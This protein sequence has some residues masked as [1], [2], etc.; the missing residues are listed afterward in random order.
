MKFLLTFSTYIAFSLK[1]MDFG[2]KTPNLIEYRLFVWSRVWE[3]KCGHN[4]VI[5]AHNEFSAKRKLKFQ[6]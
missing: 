5:S 6:I 3:P 4:L 1:S 2:A